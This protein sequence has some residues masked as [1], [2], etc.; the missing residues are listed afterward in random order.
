MYLLF[1]KIVI[2]VVS[3]AMALSNA[4]KNNSL[5][6]EITNVPN[7]EYSLCT[8]FNQNY[9]LTPLSFNGFQLLNKKE[10]KIIIRIEYYMNW[11][12]TKIIK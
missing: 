6:L 8:V 9:K 5:R 3:L 1:T 2:N 7:T 4:K 11:L 12:F 10:K